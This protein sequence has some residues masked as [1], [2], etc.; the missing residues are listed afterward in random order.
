MSTRMLSPAWI[1]SSGTRE[2]ERIIPLK[3]GEVILSGSLV[4][5]E[6]IQA[7]D[8]MR[9]DIGGIGSASVRFT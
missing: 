8:S 1:G 4:P 3:A 5:L 9:V 7:G 2:P 6:P